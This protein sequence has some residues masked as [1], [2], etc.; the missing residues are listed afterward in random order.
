MKPNKYEI[1]ECPYCGREYLPAEIFYPTTFFG[2]PTNLDREYSGK[3]LEYFG[4]SMDLTEKY[5]C[6]GCNK[7]FKVSAKV[8]FKSEPDDRNNFDDDYATP[9]S[10]TKLMLSEDL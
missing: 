5:V 8:N 7:S 3:I 9:L 2:T 10:S 1:I 4:K 6:D